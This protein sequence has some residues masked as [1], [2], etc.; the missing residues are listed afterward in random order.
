MSQLT[1]ELKS[2]MNKSLDELKM[3]RDEVR[4]QVHL[5][6]MEARERWAVLEEE[7]FEAEKAAEAAVSEVAHRALTK[8]VAKLKAFRTSLA[9]K[10]KSTPPM[11]HG[12]A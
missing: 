9:R 3:V 2:D 10:G 1:T 4:V 5:A 6:G 7:L 12:K 11:A 8:S